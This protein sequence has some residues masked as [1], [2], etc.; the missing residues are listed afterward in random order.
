MRRLTWIICASFL[1]GWGRAGWAQ[2]SG[3]AS[4][5]GIQ[6]GR[7]DVR[8]S[9]GSPSVTPWQ[10][11][12]SNATLTDN[13]DGTVTLDTSGTAT[14]G[15][16]K[17]G[18]TLSPTTAG[19]D[20]SL[21]AGSTLTL[22]DLTAGSVLFAG[23]GGLFTQD[24]AN[25][26]WD[27]T[28]NR[29]GIGTTGPTQKLHVDGGTI[30]SSYA[31]GS[32][33]TTP[34]VGLSRNSGLGWYANSSLNSGVTGFFVGTSAHLAVYVNGVQT[35]QFQDG[36]N[37]G[38]GTTSPTNL[39]SL[40]G[41][42][43]RTLWMERH[44]TANTAGN[45]LTVTAGGATAGATDKNGGNLILTSGTAT[46]TGGGD[47][48]FQTSQAAASTATTD[49]A[50]TTR[51]QLANN[52]HLESSGTAPTIATNDCGTTVQG[53]V[54]ALSTDVA[55]S[56]TAGTLAVTSCA[57][58]FA[59]AWTNAPNCVVMDDTNI[60]TVRATTTTTKLTIVS[61]TSMSSDVLSYLCIGN[62]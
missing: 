4:G 3:I 13:A 58:T 27:D 37:V 31:P 40:G 38:I 18:T 26:F 53:T 44:T 43:A 41:N 49:N 23:T 52:G 15:W 2:E 24:N 5:S 57:M 16:T 1:T 36:G 56:I 12:V 10:V 33:Q 17:T 9:D 25:L 22:A 62:I 45:T 60:L 14:T 61:T 42:S 59:K 11:N 8:E 47:I 46:G 29:L 30:F 28:N 20:V 55:G 51:L 32:I 50:L 39:V 21:G 6:P 35:A 54:T 19:D 7:L 48:V 34:A